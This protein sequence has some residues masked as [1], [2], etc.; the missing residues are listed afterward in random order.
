MFKYT[1]KAWAYSSLATGFPQ[2][3]FNV[4]DTM[5]YKDHSQVFTKHKRPNEDVVEVQGDWYSQVFDVMK[6]E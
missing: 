5:R 4:K 3:W 2:H 1:P 6:I